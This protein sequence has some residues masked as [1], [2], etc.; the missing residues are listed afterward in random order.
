MRTTVICF[1]KRTENANLTIASDVIKALNGS[2]VYVDELV[3]LDVADK[4][5]FVGALSR[6][7]EV[8][9][10]VNA[11]IAT[12]GVR[13]LLTSMNFSFDAE[14]FSVGER[15]IAVYEEN[16]KGYKNLLLEKLGLFFGVSVGKITFR[17]YGVEERSLR[18]TA[19]LISAECPSVYF[20]VSV[21]HSDGKV[22]LFYNENS[23]KMQVDK[24]IKKFI[25]TYKNA[26][27]AEDDVTL[28]QR[29]KDLLKLH[30]LTCSTAES[31]TGGAIAARIVSV[32]GA[33]DV[34]YEGMVT[35]NTLAKERRLGVLHKTVVEHTVVSS[36]VAYEMA[37]G[38]LSYVDVAISITGYAG[39]DAYPDK[40]DGLCFIGIGLKNQVE[41]YR[42]KFEGS[43]NENRLSA[44]NAALFLA[45]K[46]VQNT[47]F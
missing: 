16:K 28:E 8:T 27:Y 6:G 12:F 30:R 31:M 40:D 23:P 44:V 39:S 20:N 32:D 25:N 26:I 15:F 3:V 33:S 10:I 4:D 46:T 18:E 36:E 13:A 7:G 45:I 5:A 42:Y 22:E 38:L 2:S 34:F 21:E 11:D 14:G 43:R 37:A 9:L 1:K 29:L 24:A 17:L 47:D 41:V 35:Y 19:D